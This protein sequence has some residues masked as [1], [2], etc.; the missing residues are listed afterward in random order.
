LRVLAD[1][2]ADM[3]PGW[4]ASPRAARSGSPCIRYDGALIFAPFAGYDCAPEGLKLRDLRA[5]SGIWGAE[6]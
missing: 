3:P 5:G 1:A 6:T 2:G 4:A